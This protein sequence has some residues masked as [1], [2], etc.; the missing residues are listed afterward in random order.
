MAENDMNEMP[1]GKPI[2]RLSKLPESWFALKAML[3]LETTKKVYLTSNKGSRMTA[4][5][6]ANR[7]F[8]EIP[9]CDAVIHATP[10]NER[11]VS[12]NGTQT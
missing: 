10:A 5:T 11:N 3:K 4:K 7:H 9:L 2:L 1:S 6:I 12:R 8:R